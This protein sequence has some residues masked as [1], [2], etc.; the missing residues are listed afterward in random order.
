MTAPGTGSSAFRQ[1]GSQDRVIEKHQKPTVLRRYGWLLVVVTLSLSALLWLSPGIGRRL[2]AHSS[3]S[4]SRVTVASVQRGVFVRDIAADGKI[5]AAVSPT[6]YAPA[7]GKL[8][9]LAHAGDKVAAGAVLARL[10][11]PDLTARLVQEQETLR[12]AES[13]Y[14]RAQLEAHLQ[15]MRDQDAAAKAHVDADTAN[16][17]L[18]RSRRAHELGAYSELQV[19]RAQDALE[20]ANFS[21]AEA[22]NTLAA[23]PKQNQFEIDGRKATVERQRSLVADLQRQVDSLNIRSPVEGQVGRVQVED[24]AAVAKDAPLLTV[25]DLSALQVQIQVPESFARD[26]QNGMPAQLAGSGGQ[27]QG[28]V[29]AVSPEVVNGEVIARVSFDNAKPAGLRQNQRMSVGIVLDRRDNVLSVER[30]S[31]LDQDGGAFAYV[32]VGNVAVK[33]PI[34]VGAVSLNKVEIRAGLQAGDQI[35]ISG[36]DAL[37]GASSVV[38]SN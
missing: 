26:L 3:V 2:G 18:D 21:L 34:R 35:V 4:R 12:S 17:E 29:S 15:L 6:L 10:D 37:E 19:S 33:R 36:V 24:H 38:L 9:L 8:T 11:S 28:H 1:T 27:W 7:N 30:G 14:G 32:I 22:Q 13:E 23:R 25:V 31:F 5:I 16:R 20:K